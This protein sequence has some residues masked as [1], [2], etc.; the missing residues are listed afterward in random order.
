MAGGSQLFVRQSTGLVRE[1]NA[2]DA[3]IFN[4]VFSAPVGATL[5][6]GVFFAL[7]AFPGSDL[8]WATIISFIINIPVLLMMALL[9][10]S[11]PRTGGDYVWVSRILSPPAALVSNFGAA[12]SATIGATFW[13]RYFPVFALG[14]ILA[15]L[16]I[17]FD[18]STLI[19]WGKSFQTDSHWIFV[20]AM[21]MVVLMGAILVAGLRTTF[22]WQNAFWIIASVGTFL[23]FIVLIFGSHADF[24]NNFNSV[25][26]KYSSP[27]AATLISSAGVTPGSGPNAGNLDA[28]LPSIFVIMTFMMWNWW[29]V[30]LSGELKSAA[31]RARQLSIMFGALAWDVIFIVVGVLLLFK[32]TGYD[33]MVAV[34]SGAS[35][36]AVPTGPWYHFLSSLVYNIPILTFLIVG[37]FLFWSLPAM[38]GNTYMP[39]RTW[40]AWSFDRL[41]P[42]KLSEVNDRTHSPIWAILFEMVLVTLMLI[43][44][45]VSTDFQTWLALGVLAGVVCVVIVGVA[46]IVFPFRR[47]DL[48]QA[49]PANWKIAGVPILFIV[50]PLS[51]AVMVFLAWCTWQYP[52]LALAGNPDNRWQIFAFMGMIVVVGLAVYL[53][54]WFFRRRQGIDINLVYKELPPE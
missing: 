34:N 12:L 23:A 24:V 32:V 8:V 10:S 36:Y 41:L 54:S 5:A 35:G 49:S 22:R 47:K 37:S 17:T 6:W 3:T 19:D 16:G 4:A 20:G 9:A 52:A 15:T 48:Y 28:T 27:D 38:V 53:L 42:E 33:F 43:W 40:F 13:A 1:A 30:Y 25:S 11:M 29:S 21:V 2:L 50:A 14:P 7:T 44:S 46:A 39:I 45:I 51:I 31:N 26:A 18:N